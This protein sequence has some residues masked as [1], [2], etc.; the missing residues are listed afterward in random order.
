MILNNN[1]KHRKCQGIQLYYVY[2]K[3]SKCVLLNGLDEPCLNVYVSL[4][5][6]FGEG[7]NLL[8]PVRDK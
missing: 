4:H 2:I 8:C 3:D 1:V 7:M 5:T 6:A